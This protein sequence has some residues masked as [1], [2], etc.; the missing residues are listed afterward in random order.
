M[1]NNI[2]AV[3]LAAGRGTRMKPITDTIPKPLIEINGKTL[4]EY[5]LLPLVGIVDCFILV[6]N[7]L[8]EK[9][10]EKIGLK[11]ADT[12]V[13]Y[14]T[15]TKND[16]GT[17]D[18]V[19]TVINTIVNKYDFNYIIFNTDEIR[20]EQ[21]YNLFLE[22]I[23]KESDKVWICGKFL[24]DK[25]KLKSFGVLKIGNNNYLEEMHEKPQ[26]Y[27][28]SIIN[29]GMYY[30]PGSIFTQYYLD[31]NKN[32]KPATKERYLTD[33][34]AYLVQ[35]KLVKVVYMNADYKYYTSPEDLDK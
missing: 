12:E 31:F 16:G 19:E 23:Q 35:K 7:W 20:S 30:F 3:G 9:I 13:K 24:E 6:T 14:V 27:I 18:A 28:S 10:K 33:W 34:I 32:Y 26:K 5:N 4:L 8:E 21:F 1:K 11:F 17:L 29:I 2:I 22:N 15:Q 25:E